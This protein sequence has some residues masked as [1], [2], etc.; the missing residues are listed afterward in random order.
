MIFVSKPDRFSSDLIIPGRVSDERGFV[1]PGTVIDGITGPIA[2]HLSAEGIRLAAQR[3]PQ[4]GLIDS[5]AYDD[6]AAAF[7]EEH[8]AR[9]AAEERAKVLQDRLDRI[10][11]LKRDGFQVTRVQ[12]RP[13]QKVEAKS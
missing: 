2:V 4:L 5:V 13:R 8:E 7:A 12:G 9:E 1:V 6:L 11:G 10:S 3:F